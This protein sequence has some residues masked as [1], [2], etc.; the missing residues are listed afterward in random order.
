MKNL[1][2]V[3]KTL[4]FSAKAEVERSCGKVEKIRAFSSFDALPE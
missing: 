2:K 3:A 1:Q 4:H